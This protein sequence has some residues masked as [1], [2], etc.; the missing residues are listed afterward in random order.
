MIKLWLAADCDKM[1]TVVVLYGD[2]VTV[3]Y[4]YDLCGDVVMAAD[5]P[6]LSILYTTL[7]DIRQYSM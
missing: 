7:P 1:C 2:A 6:T 4:C 3:V 5:S